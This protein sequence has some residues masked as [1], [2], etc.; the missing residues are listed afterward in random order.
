MT[1]SFSRLNFSCPYEWHR[2][3]IECEPQESNFYAEFG[4]LVHQII[5]YYAKGIL[6]PDQLLEY[7]DNNFDDKVQ[8][9]CD[10]KRR[11]QYYNQGFDYVSNI[12]Q[13]LQLEDYDILGVEKALKFSLKER[14]PGFEERDYPFTGFIDLFLKNKKTG[15]III[16][17]N[18]SAN[19][20]F[21]RDGTPYKNQEE[22]WLAF[23]RQLYLYSY[24]FVEEG[25][26]I[27]YLSWNF[28]RQGGVFKTIPW[29]RKD[30]DKAV[31]WA[32][33]RIHFLEQEEE[34]LP[35]PDFFYCNSLCGYR[36]NCAFTGSQDDEPTI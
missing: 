33:D 36:Y 13:N 11:E 21:R 14:R 9:E 32:L 19:M 18:K 6:P 15:K 16:A 20:R 24:P 2:H 31:N 29:K 5:E 28:F 1:W 26:E 8:S 10:P 4:S 17:D 25:Q 23:Q 7:Y 27:S 3:Y 12:S 34:F 22:H 30:Y 35:K